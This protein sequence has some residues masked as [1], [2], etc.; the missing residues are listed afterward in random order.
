M[1]G[2]Q[3]A[4]AIVIDVPPREV[5]LRLADRLLDQMGEE[6]ISLLLLFVN[7]RIAM[8]DQEE[9][10]V[11]TGDLY[12]RLNC[13]ALIG[14]VGS[15]TLGAGQEEEVAF[16]ASAMALRIPDAE[17][18]VRHLVD[19]DIDEFVGM[20]CKNEQD[21]P[22]LIFADPFSFDIQGFLDRMN[23]FAHD[24][25]VLGGLASGAVSPG[26]NCLFLNDQVYNEGAVAVQIQGKMR[27]RSLVSQG[28]R[29]VG[30][31]AVITGMEE[32]I[33]TSI[34]GRPAEQW[35]AETYNDMSAEEQLLL[36]EV[37]LL[38]QV[39]NEQQENFGHGDF[40]I[41]PILKANEDGLIVPADI[42]RGTTVQLHVRDSESARLDFKGVLERFPSDEKAR[43]RAGLLLT[44]SGRGVDLFGEPHHDSTLIRE[45]LGRMP[46]A[47]FFCGGEIGP[48][49]G[50][51][52]LHGFTSSLGL[53]LD[54]AE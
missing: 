22:V 12:E 40:L 26:W 24:T 15:G 2:V 51:S 3:A 39:I 4:S 48:V 33:V 29:P 36:Q 8:A 53:F 19:D 44:C 49:G 21:Q 7:A 9:I 42:K 14:C 52:F 41:R 17:L 43:V 31:R 18:Q 37:P 35:L 10:Q 25:P 13:Q 54:A 47:G 27:F 16:S 50:V 34:K 38:G 28:C 46:L 20:H 11:I 32:H 23:G 45:Q 30:D 5:G 1:T 6:P